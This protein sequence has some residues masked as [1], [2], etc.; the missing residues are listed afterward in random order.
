[1]THLGERIT[2]F[3]FGELSA[4]EME[5]AR[6]HVAEC[7][8]CRAD[9]LQF[10][11]TRSMLRASPDVEP[12]R[13]I[14]FE[15]EKPRV[16]WRWLAP[17]GVAAAVILAVL[18]APPMQISFHDSQFT[19]T[20]GK[21]PPPANAGVAAVPVL[22]PVT[23]QSVDYDR[24]IRQVETSQQGWVVNELKK[25]DADQVR[26]IQRLQGQL[27]YLANMQQAIEKKNIE[28]AASIQ[29]LA[30]RTGAQD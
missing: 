19:M 5:E 28:N 6:R 12:P 9:V 18:V 25:H 11:N 30:E 7:V 3:V 23:V 13:R 26:E 4:S 22:T 10:E 16:A 24:I 20:F 15:V 14:V 27:V 29:L 17:I 1:M 2:D 21:T 8:E